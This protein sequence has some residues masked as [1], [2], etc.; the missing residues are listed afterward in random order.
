[1]SEKE[2]LRHKYAAVHPPLQHQGRLAETLRQ[3]PIYQQA[4]RLFLSPSQSLSQLRINALLDGKEIIL[5]GPGLKE[6]FYLL[7]PFSIPLRELSFAVSLKGIASY[8]TLQQL[9][10]LGAHPIELLLTEALA[11]DTS[12]GRLGDGSGF[13]DLSCAIL[14]HL[15]GLAENVAA[16]ALLENDGWAEAPLPL[17]PWDVTMQGIISPMG[18]QPLQNDFRAGEIIWDALPARWIRKM[19]PLWKIRQQ[20]A[21]W[22]DL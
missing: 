22:S 20:M 16:L 6:G 12:G 19:T 13:F 4:T 15:G 8:G 10:H 2:A 14:A 11:V 18:F 17:D 5:P 9:S 3:L 1:M 7:T 21:G